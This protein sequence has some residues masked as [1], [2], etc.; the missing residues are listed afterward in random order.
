M[1]RIF[2]LRL[3]HPHTL[4]RFLSAVEGRRRR[5]AKPVNLQH[6]AHFRL[7]PPLIIGP[8]LA[9]YHDIQSFKFSTM[10]FFPWQLFYST[11]L[12]TGTNM[13]NNLV[14]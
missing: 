8:I 13:I 1:N 9:W 11:L 12:Y 14:Q 4:I 10:A 7:L 3:P 6:I 5:S 2:L